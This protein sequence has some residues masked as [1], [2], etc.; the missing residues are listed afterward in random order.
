[1]AGPAAAARPAP[2]APAAGWPAGRLARAL[3]LGSGVVLMV[4]VA[5]HLVNH[6]LGVF[7]VDAMGVMQEWRSEVWRSWPGTVLLYGAAAVH[8]G[9]VLWRVVRRATWRMP[10]MEA[11]QILLGLSIP[12]LLYNH[13]IGTRLMASVAGFDDSYANLLRILWPGLA[14]SQSLLL[15]VVWA[16]GVI[17]IWFAA[18]AKPW[19]RRLKLPFIITAVVVPLLA[20]AGFIAAARE[21]SRMTAPPI[22]FSEAHL[23]AYAAAT[24]RVS[25]AIWA[26]LGALALWFAVRFVWMRRSRVVDVRFAGHGPLRSPKGL[27]LLEMARLHGLPHAASCGGRGRCAT[28]RVM[29]IGGGED[30]PPPGDIERR[31]LDRIRAPQQ[32]RLACQTRPTGDLVVRTLLP[33]DA[34]ERGRLWHAQPLEW[35]EERVLTV[36]FADMRGFS[37]LARFQPPQDLVQLLNRLI[38][39]LSQATERRGGRVAMIETDGVMAVFGLAGSPA[40]GARAALDAAADMLRCVEVMNRDAGLSVSQPLRIGVGVHTGGVVATDV[41]DAERGYQLVVI[42]TP[43]V[44]ADRLQEATKEHGADCVAS[45]ATLEFA[46]LA[47]AAKRTVN[48]SYKGADAPAPAAV[49]ADLPALEAALGRKGVRAS[50]DASPEAAPVPDA[51]PARA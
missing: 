9:L 30:L 15:V 7:G 26:V 45:L 27:T 51:P 11:A 43:V 28:C 23:A 20:I 25:L 33:A 21:A 34:G 46:G 1:M 41:G 39:E 31:T 8:V 37:N 22:A 6:A 50:G 2:L 42:G 10:L 36:L 24:S 47:G 40:Q 16:H 13:V 5:T 29:V 3:R 32:V 12:L 4:F 14:L 19:F 38:D 48:V 17:G 18:A 49:F 35:G 44:I